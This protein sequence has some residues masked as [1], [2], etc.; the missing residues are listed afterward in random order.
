MDNVDFES[1]E[2][3]ASVRALA[4]KLK[5]AQHHDH[6]TTLSA[7]CKLIQT[8]FSKEALAKKDKPKKKGSSTL[9]DMP[10]GFSTNDPIL[11]KAAKILRLCFINDLRK[12]QTQIN[13]TIVQ[14]QN[15][16][17]NPKTDTR[18]GKVGR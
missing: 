12:L 2:F 1:D 10:L 3:K 14:V 7:C 5:I 16:T 9:L 15:I 8:S 11:D 17:A 4:N 18:L 13:E 6:L